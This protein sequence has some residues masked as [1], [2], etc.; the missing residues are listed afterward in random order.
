MEGEDIFLEIFAYLRSSEGKQLIFFISVPTAVGL[1]E[2][3]LTVAWD[4]AV[5]LSLLCLPLHYRFQLLA[6][7]RMTPN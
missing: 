4:L 1:S 3:S 2:S 6:L 5:L 7:H